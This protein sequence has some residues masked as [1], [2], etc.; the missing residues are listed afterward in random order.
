MSQ[1]KIQIGRMLLDAGIIT[2]EQLTEAIQQQRASG[3]RL[4]QVFVNLG[5]V[6]EN[7]ILELLSRQLDIPLVD[8][9]NY[10]LDPAVVRSLPEM[11]A[12][13]HRAIVIERDDKGY[14]IAMADPQDVVATDE[15][16]HILAEPVR[17]VL[18]REA[19]IVQSIDMT[20]RRSEEISQLAEE[21]SAD[22]TKN[23]FDLARLT[24]GQTETDAPILKLLQ[25]I[26]QDAVQTDASDVHIEPDENLLRI[27]QR[28]DGVLHE[29]ILKEKRVAG[30]LALRL[31]LMAGLNITE[32]RLPQDGRFSLRI[33]GQNFDVRL[34]TLP[35]QFGESV[36]MRLLNQSSHVP[37][38]VKMGAPESMVQRLR[39]IVSLPNGLFLVTGPTGS[40]KTTTLYSL[41][42]N[43][44]EPGRKIITVED[45]VEYRMPRVSQVQ[46][47]SRIDLTFARVL[48][49]I[50][51]QDPD[52]IMIGELRDQETATIAM[53]AAMTGHLVLATLHTNDSASTVIRLLDM[54]V[55]GY[56]V[57]SV[58]RAVLAQRLIRRI[59][60]NCT[61]PH[62]LTLQESTWVETVAPDFLSGN[63]KLQQGAGCAQCHNTG[64]S[65]RLGVFEL[66]EMNSALADALRVQDTAL[67]SRLVRENRQFRSLVIN[68]LSLAS[69]GVTTVSE[70]IR[71]AGESVGMDATDASREASLASE[72]S[73]S[74]PP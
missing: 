43:L 53:R 51:R 26:F 54:G 3:D 67:F 31:K 34:S 24:E 9:K 2:G 62:E 29:Q 55:E 25:S 23:D 30:A 38:L 20:Y 61:V 36:V 48:R 28:I 65:G 70:I 46:V 14:L 47:Q 59:C 37:D 4:G 60:R 5:Y 73:A 7:I 16:A 57:A 33:H 66:L 63:Q 50:L 39:K 17:I 42:G 35:V 71:I 64:Y 41:L 8:I 68:G 45:P 10:S 11:H 32:K 44:N 13:R 22:I 6:K 49:S 52:V 21:V 74:I 18:A 56:I 1:A 19:D 40:G 58:L 72:A 12:R 69:T 15:L 27:R